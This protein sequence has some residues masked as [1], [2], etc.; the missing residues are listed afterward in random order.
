M[1]VWWSFVFII[2][3]IFFN[4]HIQCFNRQPIGSV[5][6]GKVRVTQQA[7]LNFI[8]ALWLRQ[9]IEKF[10]IIIEVFR[11]TK[12]GKIEGI[13]IIKILPS[14][15]E[16]PP[17]LAP[18][19]SQSSYLLAYLFSEKKIFWY[20]NFH[21]LPIYW[22]LHVQSCQLKYIFQAKNQK[23]NF[24]RPFQGWSLSLSPNSF[25]FCLYSSSCAII[26]CFSRVN[27][28]RSFS[29]KSESSSF[30]LRSLIHSNVNI[31]IVLGQ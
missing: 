27:L 18:V 10:F 1:T 29:S 24:K 25:S 11:L 17:L 4:S 2:I 23:I 31:K 15:G 9:L 30:L 3:Y 13:S 12:K 6:A 7:F 14:V 21:K 16:S 20:L 28:I 19:V 26:F 5:F 8:K 22:R